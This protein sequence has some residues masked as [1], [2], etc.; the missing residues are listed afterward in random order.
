MNDLGNRQWNI[1]KLREL[2]EEILPEHSVF[3]EFQVEHN[4]ETIGR[5]IMCLNVRRIYRKSNQT[6]LILLAIEDVTDQEYYKKDLE[7][8]VK[9]RTAELIIAKEESEKR[10]Q[11]AEA[12]LSETKKLKDQLE[13]E[14]MISRWRFDPAERRANIVAA[15]IR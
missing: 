13:A 15:M 8:I 4:F 5:K 7:E 1:P 3:N 6:Q 10:K 9:N 11:I 12:A 14:R 2:L